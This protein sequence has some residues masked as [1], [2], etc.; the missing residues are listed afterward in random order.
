MEEEEKK[1]HQETKEPERKEEGDITTN[2]YVWIVGAVI[3]LVAGWFGIKALLGPSEN[4]K[5]TLIDAPKE[6][7]SGGIATFTWRVD[8]PPVLIHHP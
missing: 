2:K 4:Y 8:G 1:E 6:V 5:V 7:T 3:L